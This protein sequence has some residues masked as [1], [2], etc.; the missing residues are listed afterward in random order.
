MKIVITGATGFIGSHVAVRLARA[1][2]QVVATG[3][4]PRKVP[5]L[6]T[7]PGISLMRLELK[8]PASWAPAL[9]GADVLVHV[10]LGWGEGALPMLQADTAASVGLFEAAHAAGVRRIIY[11]SSTAAVGEQRGDDREDCPLRPTDYY[12]ATK[13]STE[14]FAR[15]FARTTKVPVHV[16]RPGYIF[17]EPAVEGANIYSD[18][19][20]R[21]ICRAVREAQPVR[22]IQNDGTQFL[23][24]SNLAKVYEALLTHEVGFSTHFALAKDWCSWA[25]I[26]RMAM[27]GYGREVPIEF[28]DR[29]YGPPL[30][31]NLSAIERDFGLAFQSREQL[32]TH[33]DWVLSVIP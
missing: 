9:A 5:S 4:N 33:V 10:A 2:H 22:L 17:G 6:G 30:L 23:H 28:E 32:R 12:G 8:D 7:V 14:M 15:A 1:G 18:T 20:F 24:A 13:A 31:Y 21:N 16:I 25:D 29:G 3:R 11:T 27:A 26:A 19:R